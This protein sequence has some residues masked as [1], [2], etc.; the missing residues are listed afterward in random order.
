M[1]WGKDYDVN[2]PAGIDDPK[3]GDDEIRDAKEA[4]RERLDIDHYFPEN[5]PTAGLVNNADTGEHKKVSLRKI[6]PAPSAVANKGF[7]Y[8][9]ESGGAGVIELFYKDAAGNE[10]QLTKAGVLRPLVA[11]E[12]ATDAV[13]TDKIKDSAVT[14]DK[15]ASL[16][17]ATAKIATAAVT[18]TKLGTGATLIKSGN[19][20]GD[21]GGSRSIDIG[22]PYMTVKCVVVWGG[23]T[24]PADSGTLALKTIDDSSASCFVIVGNNTPNLNMYRVPHG[25]I[26]FNATGFNIDQWVNASSIDYGYIAIGEKL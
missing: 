11:A 4:T 6:D 14:S 13:E 18:S 7:V 16:A 10:I 3:K 2:S 1:A 26:E 25:I 15:I 19:Y 5:D 21:G 8:T 20:T 12:L 9:K 24:D 17:V 23:T 22:S